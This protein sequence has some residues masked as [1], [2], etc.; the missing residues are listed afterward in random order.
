MSLP[1]QKLNSGV[2]RKRVKAPVIDLID[3]DFQGGSWKAML[4]KLQIPPYDC[5]KLFLY[6]FLHLLFLYD[7]FHPF[8]ITLLMLVLFYFFLSFP[9]FI[10]CRLFHL[11]K[12]TL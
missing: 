6:Y 7:Y 4:L 9:K 3:S 8:L 12:N 2:F 1:E 10:V 5:K 11:Q